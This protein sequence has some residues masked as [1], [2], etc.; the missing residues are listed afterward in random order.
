[1]TF[2]AGAN[3]RGRLECLPLGPGAG[4]EGYV[5]P[6]GPRSD[7]AAEATR[8]PVPPVPRAPRAKPKA[9]TRGYLARE[10]RRDNPHVELCDRSATPPSQSSETRRPRE[11]SPFTYA[12]KHSL[13][14]E[15]NDRDNQAFEMGPTR[16]NS[17]ERDDFRRFP[18]AGSCP[19]EG[20]GDLVGSMLRLGM[21]GSCPPESGG[22]QAQQYARRRTLQRERVAADQGFEW[23]PECATGTVAQPSEPPSHARRRQLTR[24]N[25]VADRTDGVQTFGRVMCREGSAPPALRGGPMVE[26]TNL[27]EQVASYGRKSLLARDRNGSNGHEGQTFNRV[28]GR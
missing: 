10:G 22:E 12:R 5:H 18:R 8:P 15:R 4:A 3:G 11:E 9:N 21:G 17:E 19:P 27:M 6:V 14:R 25:D 2:G 13:T 26:Q 1:M 24:E 16:R 23:A 28:L 20:E 7:K